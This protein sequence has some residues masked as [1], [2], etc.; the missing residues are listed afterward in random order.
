MTGKGGGAASIPA[1]GLGAVW[2]PQ[3]HSNRAA[4]A[5]APG[6]LAKIQPRTR[7]ATLGLPELICPI[8]VLIVRSQCPIGI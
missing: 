8:P 2:L 7:P 6:L 3:A 5:A 1:I 4:I